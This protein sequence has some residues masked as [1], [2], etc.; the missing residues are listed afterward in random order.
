MSN[1]YI[2]GRPAASRVKKQRELQG[3]R[4]SSQITKFTR[5]AGH[6]FVFT[7]LPMQR[8]NETERRCKLSKIRKERSF[9]T[10]RKKNNQCLMKYVNLLKKK[11]TEASAHTQKTLSRLESSRIG[12]GKNSSLERELS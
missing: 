6:I 5:K 4:K 1:L 2:R 9:S 10:R 7:E 11:H 3:Q 8:K 12:F